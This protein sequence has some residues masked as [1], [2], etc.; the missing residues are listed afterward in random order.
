[1]RRNAGSLFVTQWPK[2]NPPMNTAI[3]AKNRIEEIECANGADADEVKQRAFDAQVGEG[4]VQ[5]L[6]DSVASLSSYV[7]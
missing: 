4:L 1:M 2:A 3:P 5:A 6:E 7:I